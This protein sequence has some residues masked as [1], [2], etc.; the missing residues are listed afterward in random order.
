M[1]YRG[2]SLRISMTLESYDE[3]HVGR[4][5]DVRCG[6]DRGP[7]CG[8]SRRIINMNRRQLT[9]QKQPFEIRVQ[10]DLLFICRLQ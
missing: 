1:S 2:M 5:A 10:T 9:C 7:L 8:Q 6:L 4:R 3:Q